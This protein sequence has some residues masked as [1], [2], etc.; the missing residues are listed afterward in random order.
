MPL[1]CDISK[2]ISPEET[3]IPFGESLISLRNL[4]SSDDVTCSLVDE[5]MS[6]SIEAC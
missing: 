1:R 6:R 2:V 5:I 3:I 4:S